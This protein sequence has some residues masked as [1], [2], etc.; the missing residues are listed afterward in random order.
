MKVT[1][2]IA[3]LVAIAFWCSLHVTIVSGVENVNVI[4]CIVGSDCHP[5]VVH[6]LQWRD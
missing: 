5:S 2:T 3:V 6:R 1:L 4:G